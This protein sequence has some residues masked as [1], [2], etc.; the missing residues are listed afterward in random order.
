[1]TASG[2]SG[3]EKL[4]RRHAIKLAPAVRCS[5]E[6]CS[7]AVG[8]VVGYG[9]IKSA[10]RMNNSVVV[11]LDSVDKVNRV[12]ESGVVIQDT[13]TPV[14]SLVN[15]A[16]KVII[17]NVP[18]FIRNEVLAKE[19]SRHGQ[20]VSP[21]KLIPLGCKSPQLKHVMS[22]RRQVF[23]ILNRNEEDLHLTFKF[24]VDDFDY[25]LHVTT[26]NMKCF[27]CGMEGHLVRSC[28]ERG[29]AA[30]PAPGAEPPGP[31]VQPGPAPA[32]EPPG[33]PVRAAS[34]GAASQD[35][36]IQGDTSI[37][38]TAD[39]GSPDSQ[40]DLEAE[41][42]VKQGNDSRNQEEETVRKEMS[43]MGQT[44]ARVA[45]SV[46]EEEEEECM[47]E[48]VVKSSVKRKN[49]E[50]KQVEGRIKKVSKSVTECPS[51]QPEERFH[52]DCENETSENLE[53]G[54]SFIRV[55]KFLQ[56]TKG[57]RQV[58][59]DNYFPDLQ[60]FLDSVKVYMKNIEEF[61]Q[62][63]FSDQ[64]ISRLKKNS[65]EGEESNTH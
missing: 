32:A 33:S 58:K 24:K 44:A 29:G 39:G 46:L 27:G 56:D 7:L 37:K 21:I 61:V 65:S 9:S 57:L 63:V 59:V 48:D 12:V 28:P 19:L 8:E 64:E 34:S 60:L 35:E 47:D 1:M 42:G 2:G 26:D 43:R 38:E 40:T 18:P 52:S 30:G 36:N 5:V 20:L 15:L 11:F 54:Y 14:F 53:S 17:S 6:E 41:T 50:T 13:F 3:L 31:P 16:K 23:M 22:F 10:S 25:T 62:P 4:T 55:Q 49:T 45:E 51:S